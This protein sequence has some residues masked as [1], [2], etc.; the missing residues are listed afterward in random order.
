MQTFNIW[1]Q[2][3]S[4]WQFLGQLEAKSLAKIERTLRKLGVDPETVVA[5]EAALDPWANP[6]SGS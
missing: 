3:G 6:R 5:R 4:A 2:S 1:Q